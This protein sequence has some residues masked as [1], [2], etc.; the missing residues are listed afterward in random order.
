MFVRMCPTS[1]CLNQ[2][3]WLANRMREQGIDFQQGSNAF[4][5]CARPERLQELADAL[6]PRDLIA[7]GQK[8][9]SCFTPVNGA[10]IFLKSGAAKFP[11]LAGW[12]SARGVIGAS[13]F[14]RTATTLQG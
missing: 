5:R 10:A 11:I 2:H 14:W 8:W 9:L 1:R 3:H 6:T 7:C 12:R 13:V 4:M